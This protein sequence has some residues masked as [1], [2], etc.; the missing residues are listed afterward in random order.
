MPWLNYT[1]SIKKNQNL[2]YFCKKC[3][4][5]AKRKKTKSNISHIKYNIGHD[6]NISFV[7]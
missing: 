5:Y 4:A 3:K 6:T 7:W 1:V 2:N